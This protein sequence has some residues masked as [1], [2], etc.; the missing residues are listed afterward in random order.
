VGDLPLVVPGP[1]DHPEVDADV[2]VAVEGD[3]LAVGRPCRMVGLQP[4]RGMGELLEIGAV[5]ERRVELLLATL[6]AREHDATVTPGDQRTGRGRERGPEHTADREDRDGDSHLLHPES[7]P[8]GFA[9]RRL[10]AASVGSALQR[11]GNEMTSRR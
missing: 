11:C 8:H 7:V 4:C 10:P 3:P 9:L 5:R 2:V 1:A 6:V